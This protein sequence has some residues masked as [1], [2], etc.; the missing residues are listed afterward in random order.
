MIKNYCI[1]ENEAIALKKALFGDR[2]LKDSEGKITKESFDAVSEITKLSSADRKKIFTDILGEKGGQIINRGFEQRMIPHTKERLDELVKK[3]VETG[4]TRPIDEIRNELIADKIAIQKKLLVDFVNR[5]TAKVPNVNQKRLITRIEKIKHILSPSEKNDFLSDI[6]EQKFGLAISPE[7][8][9]KIVEMADA[10][11]KSADGLVVAEKKAMETIIKDVDDVFKGKTGAIKIMP[12]GKLK[13]SAEISLKA[14]KRHAGI[15]IF[16]GEKK[17]VD[18]KLVNTTR[19]EEYKRYQEL[20]K[21]NIEEVLLIHYVT[22]L[23]D[24]LTKIPFTRKTFGQALWR[25]VTIPVISIEKAIKASWDASVFLRQTMPELM[26]GLFDASVG[27]DTTRLKRYFQNAGRAFK[28]AF[29]AITGKK[30]E[31]IKIGDEILQVKQYDIM[32]AGLLSRYE[33]R[34]GMVD[35]ADGHYGM[36]IMREEPFV[37]GAPTKIPILGR[38]FEASESLFSAVSLENRLRGMRRLIREAEMKGLDV[39]DKD[40]AN[41]LSDITS[42]MTGRGKPFGIKKL[43][44]ISEL[45]NILFFAPRFVGAQI[46]MLLQLPK[47]LIKG[48]LGTNTVAQTIA[49]KEASKALL[50]NAILVGGLMLANDLHNKESKNFTVERN[51]RASTFGNIYIGDKAY[52]LT[53]GYSTTIIAVAKT[54]ISFAGGA[55]RY[56]PLTETYSKLTFGENTS[57]ILMTFLGNKKSPG[58]GI[59]KSMIN[60]EMFGGEDFWDTNTFWR[61]LTPIT[62]ENILEDSGFELTK[63]LTIVDTISTDAFMTLLFEGLGMSQRDIKYNPKDKTW[64]ALKNKD[65]NA[66][67]KAVEYLNVLISDEVERLRKDTS[68]QKANQEDRRKIIE[69]FRRKTKKNV[70]SKFNFGKE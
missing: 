43:E 16:E 3:A 49:T 13:E 32:K 69:S 28:I 47:W 10:A 52:D 65:A 58:L 19:A 68:Y 5:E 4:D 70:E 51:I 38:G 39:F 50:S 2:P 7:H 54:L 8:G 66:Y 56:D 11:K 46:E 24:E 29:S 40:V 44:Q 57:D 41:P 12:E 63:P 31:A 34:S 62:F 26:G 53:G 20:A 36:N 18:G 33:F 64:I 22:E 21:A 42:A 67:K 30:A 59:L 15:D 35:V 14:E 45:L 23:T 55:P 17:I 25:R 37:S 60:N 27:R 61:L 9:K 6:V 48:G 1:P